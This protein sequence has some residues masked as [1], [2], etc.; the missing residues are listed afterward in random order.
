MSIGDSQYATRRH[1]CQD[2][3]VAGALNA[4]A[5]KRD[6]GWTID[7]RPPLAQRNPAYRRRA[8]RCD[9]TAIEDGRGFASGRVVEHD[10]GTDRRKARGAIARKRGNPLDSKQVRRARGIRL[11]QQRRH[12][13]GVRGG[14][15]WVDA[16][17][18]RKLGRV[19][20]R[21]QRAPRERYPLLDRWHC[22]DHV[23]RG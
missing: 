17:L 5:H 18:W 12:G 16:D 1:A 8:L 7:L 15:T 10:Q 14:L 13:R 21:D 20:E 9:R 2:L 3:N 11:T 23:G 19:D 4:R 22:G 6:P